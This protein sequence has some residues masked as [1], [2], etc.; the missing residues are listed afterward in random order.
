MLRCKIKQKHYNT[1]GLCNAHT[2]THTHTYL[3]ESRVEGRQGEQVA[4]DFEWIS[5]GNYA[6]LPN[7][8]T[9]L[10]LSSLNPYCY[11]L[12]QPSPSPTTITHHHHPS[13]PITTTHHHHPSFTLTISIT[14]VSTP[15]TPHSLPHPFPSPYR[16]HPQTFLPVTHPVTSANQP[17]LNAR[18]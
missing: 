17:D 7:L 10:Y 8:G 14:F 11:H 16:R 1:H 18:Q 6:I 15:I 5:E 12:L 9:D 3:K 4:V 2:H 13:S